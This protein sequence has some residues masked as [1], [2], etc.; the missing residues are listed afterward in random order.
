[1]NT[2]TFFWLFTFF[3]WLRILPQIHCIHFYIGMYFHFSWT[4]SMEWNCSVISNKF[5]SLC[6]TIFQNGSSIIYS[7]LR[8]SSLL[9]V[10]L[11]KTSSWLWS[12]M[13]W[14]SW[15]IF[16][17]GLPSYTEHILMYLLVTCVSSLENCLF[18]FLTCFSNRLFVFVLSSCRSPLYI[19]Y[20][21]SSSDMIHKYSLPFYWFSFP[22][23]GSIILGKKGSSS[24]CNVLHSCVYTFGIIAW[25]L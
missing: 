23:L 8:V 11:I 22:Y 4:H 24:I 9:V 6:Q 17:D 13:S 21:S 5:L 1:M 16:P 14:W 25:G 3:W 15:L 12:D 18:K 10:I 19:M 7:Y 20:I 2:Y